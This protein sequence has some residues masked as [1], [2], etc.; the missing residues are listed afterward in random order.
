MELPPPH[1]QQGLLLERRELQAAMD[2][3]ADTL[4]TER[5]QRAKLEEALQAAHSAASTTSGL[6]QPGVA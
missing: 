3:L 4:Q 1:S 5:Q 6:T 2:D